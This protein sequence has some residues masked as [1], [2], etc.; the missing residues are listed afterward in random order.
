MGAGMGDY[1]PAQGYR[2]QISHQHSQG[3]ARTPEL[4]QCSRNQRGRRRMAGLSYRLTGQ[5]AV[6][7]PA[8]LVS[9]CMVIVSGGA[10]AC[11]KSEFEAVVSEAANALR[12]LNQKHKP[13]YQARLKELKD[14][15]G[16]SHDQFLKEAAPLV[17][18]TKIAEYDERSAAFLEKIQTVGDEG[19][20]TAKPQ[21]AALT[22]VRAMM[23]SLVEAQTAKWSYMFG[24][25]EQELKR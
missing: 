13:S 16:W 20:S 10:D 6:W 24:K 22:E 5:P 3:L 2:Q 4:G 7:G 9:L 8:S 25:I 18:D 17:Q 19:S 15:R 11:E 21:C 1:L 23:K 14:K 12:D